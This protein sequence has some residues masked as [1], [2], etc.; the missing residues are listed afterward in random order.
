MEQI[1]AAT[2][3]GFLG[4]AH[5]AGMCGGFFVLA[6]KGRLNLQLQYLVGKTLSYAAVGLIAGLLGAGAG[7]ILPFRSVLSVAIG[8]LLIGIGL[9][10]TGLAPTTRHFAKLQ[11][12]VARFFGKIL[13]RSGQGAPFFVGLANGLLPCGLLYGGLGLAL[14]T[15]DPLLA[16][17]TM[18]SFGL[19]TIPGLVIFGIA[20][21]KLSQPFGRH[22]HLA[23]GI[24]MMLFGTITL[25][26]TFAAGA[27]GLH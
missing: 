18:A 10:W 25:L 23:G 7:L 8:I 19:G 13:Q 12:H 9:S 26:R 5:C 21:K 22:A 17:A 3:L 6:G 15:A 14:S 27:H 2:A 16:T 4:S 20:A 1:F 24:L 11:M